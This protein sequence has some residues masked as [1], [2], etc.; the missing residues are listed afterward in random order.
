[1]SISY[2]ITSVAI[3]GAGWIQRSAR[4]RGSRD[5]LRA[6]SVVVQTRRVGFANAHVRATLKLHS[7]NEKTGAP[8]RNAPAPDLLGDRGAL[9]EL[10]ESLQD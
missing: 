10:R 4:P 5:P 6:H 2:G 3:L 7:A 9:L 1:M 8:A